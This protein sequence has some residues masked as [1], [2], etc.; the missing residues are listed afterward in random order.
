V[1]VYSGIAGT[2]TGFL[3]RCLVSQERGG[4]HEG[5]IWRPR[6][7]KI[8]ITTG[9]V[10]AEF[11]GTSVADLDG[12]HVLVGFLDDDYSLPVILRGIPH[13]NADIGNQRRLLG[14]RL[15][16]KSND[17][18]FEAEPGPRFWKHRGAFFGVDETGSFLVDLTRAHKG[19]YDTKG[20]EPRLPDDALDESDFLN[21]LNGETGQL[22]IKIQKGSKLQIEGPEG[23]LVIL[24][25]SGAIS[26]ENANA[27][28]VI[29]PNGRVI[30]TVGSEDVEVN[31]Q[32]V[33]VNAQNVEVN[34][35]DMN[36]VT[37]TVELGQGAIHPV[38][39]GDTYNA[40]HLTMDTTLAAFFSAVAP[41]AAAF[42]SAA[43]VP[44]GVLELAPL[45]TLGP[46]LTAFMA[47]A[48][49]TGVLAGQAIT[50]FDTTAGSPTPGPPSALSLFVKAR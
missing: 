41:A 34:A 44:P 28:V 20:R 8:D 42:A 27:S 1:L 43:I 26:V 12:D 21:P 35:N 7:A 38:I 48:G 24:S 45:P 17:T 14:H 13:P 9:V 3:P 19:S 18:S 5:E 2:R 39:H 36:V 29:Q 25:Q 4:M 15:R 10:D 33:Q 6:E 50:A 22:N 30:I 11:Q 32:N 46:L 49:S 37:S 47:A 40:A 23:Q 31:A 16:S